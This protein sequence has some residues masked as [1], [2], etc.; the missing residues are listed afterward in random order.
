[1]G[2]ACSCADSDDKQQ[3]VRTDAVSTTHIINNIYSIET[4]KGRR[5]K[6]KLSTFS[7]G[8]EIAYIE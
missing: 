5:Q 2:Q 1:M 8:Q 3:E 6:L 4:S 7:T